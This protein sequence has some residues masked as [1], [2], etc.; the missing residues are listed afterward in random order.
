[1][2]GADPPAK[3]TLAGSRSCALDSKV[4]TLSGHD[5]QV[6]KAFGARVRVLSTTF[7]HADLTAAA[8]TETLNIGAVPAGAFIVGVSLRAYTPFTGGSVSECVV[9]IG[10]AGDDNGLI[11]AANVFAAAVDGVTSTRPL[12][13]SPNKRYAAATTLQ[14]KFTATGDNVVNLTAGAVT[15]DVLYAQAN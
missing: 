3:S 7:G 13:I 4:K 2:I 6:N 1:M 9:D 11:A 12:G 5:S 8:V 14:A 15:V 10:E